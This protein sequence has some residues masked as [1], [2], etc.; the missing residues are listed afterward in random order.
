MLVVAGHISQQ[1]QSLD[2]NVLS[3][4]ARQFP[5]YNI[6]QVNHHNIKAVILSSEQHRN[7]ND[8]IYEDTQ[9][10]LFIVGTVYNKN[11]IAAEAKLNLNEITNHQ[12]LLIQAYLVLGEGLFERCYGKWICIHINKHTFEITLYRDHLGMLSIYYYRKDQSFYFSTLLTTLMR[13]KDAPRQLNK[14]QLGALLLGYPGKPDETSYERI[15]KSTN[16]LKS[17]FK[18][19]FN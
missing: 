5:F 8:F 2:N 16:C 10:I 3:E 1:N 17:S 7:A 19:R 12:Q 15:K 11:Q 9:Q 6:L 14:R 13:F 4:V 18:I